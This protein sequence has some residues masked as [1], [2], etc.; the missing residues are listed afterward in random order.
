M[1]VMGFVKFERFF[2]AA[3]GVTVDRDD[4]KRYLDFVN[5]A[6]YGLLGLDQACARSSASSALLVR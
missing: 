3:G 2:R 6:L 5:D 4:V 1:P